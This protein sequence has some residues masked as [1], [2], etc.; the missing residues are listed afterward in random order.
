MRNELLTCALAVTALVLS[1][2]VSSAQTYSLPNDNNGCPANCRQI[3]WQAGS[4]IWNGGSLP[5]YPDVACAGLNNNGTTD[6]TSAINSCISAQSSTFNAS[7]QSCTNPKAVDI[8]AGVYYVAGKVNMK[9]CVVLRGVKRV[10]TPWMPTADLSET[11][12]KFGTSAQIDFEGTSGTGTDK[13]VDA[14]TVLTKGSNT[15]TMAAGHGFATNDWL[16]IGEKAD[17]NLV[18]DINGCTWCGFGS[19]DQ[20]YYMT[21]IFQATNVTGNTVTMSKPLYY[22]FQS[23]LTPVV[24]KITVGTIR[25]GLENMRLDGSAYD[26]SAFIH[27]SG[28]VEDWVKGV[29]TYMTGSASKAAH[30]Y[31]EQWNYGIEIR[32]SHFHHSRTVSSDCGY[33]IYVFDANSDIKVENNIFRLGRH[34]IAQ[35]GGGSGNA[36]LYNYSD[37][38]HTDD[39]TYLGNATS[40]HGPHPFMNLFEG[41]TASHLMA[42]HVF[43]TS[44]HTVFFR[45]WLW[46]DETGPSTT[47]DPVNGVPSWPPSGNGFNAIDVGY[48]DLYYSFVGNLLGMPASYWGGSYGSNHANWANATIRGSA[49]FGSSLSNPYVY[50]YE[51]TTSGITVSANATSL[52]HGNY[53]YKT[54]G[55]AYW[56]G[57]A[58]HTLPSSMYYSSKP[59]FFGSTPWP[60][61]GPDVSPLTTTI[62]AQSCYNTGTCSAG[63]SATPDLSFGSNISIGG[64]VSTQ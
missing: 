2:G 47:T 55:V 57:G 37:N 11:T 19:S 43:P 41:N 13:T 53:D 5:V 34:H 24:R 17:P 60:A 50:S 12:L 54:L 36:F 18:F 64:N 14:A 52:N 7:T 61:F 23:A 32:D 44:S 39:T 21:Q 28:S 9:S 15:L 26:H 31:L 16:V 27:F 10:T 38:G 3:T 63:M 4:D 58:N 30:V 6:N 51:T 1:C 59:A 42:D 48:G 45:N 62:P 46:G 40:A 20:G 56:E 29:E 49:Y 8:P 22:T 35:E 33:G 25:A